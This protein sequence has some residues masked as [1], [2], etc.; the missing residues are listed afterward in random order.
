[1]DKNLDTD[2][3]A[4]KSGIYVFV[5]EG[6]MHRLFELH[7]L[8]QGEKLC[9]RFQDDFA[10]CSGWVIVEPTS[11]HFIDSKIKKYDKKRICIY[12]LFNGHLSPVL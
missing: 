3:L 5:C 11:Y 10:H 1:M 4:P 2:A 7:R 12:N 9:K 8:Q 6:D